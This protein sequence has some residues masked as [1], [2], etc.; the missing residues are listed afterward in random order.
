[1]TGVQTCALPIWPGV[2]YRV[3]RQ[4]PKI[5]VR[6]AWWRDDP[7]DHRD[8]VIAL[9][10][11]AYGWSAEAGSALPEAPDDA[12]GTVGSAGEGGQGVGEE[13]GDRFG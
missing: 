9:A 7:P 11:A 10:R 12:R 5:S 8:E 6:L 1:M 13:A 3:L 2:A 4:A